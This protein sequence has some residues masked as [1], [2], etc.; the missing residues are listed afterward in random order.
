[1]K[2]KPQSVDH[3]LLTGFCAFVHLRIARKTTADLSA[4]LHISEKN[5]SLGTAVRF[6]VLNMTNALRLRRNSWR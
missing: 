5:L 1:L 2:A 6:A 3:G 4:L